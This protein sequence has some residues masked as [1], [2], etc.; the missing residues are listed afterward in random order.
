MAKT[1]HT[2]EVAEKTGTDGEKVRIE[3]TGTRETRSTEESRV[4]VES[5]PKQLQPDGR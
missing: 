5:G 4:D 3:T 2:H 1:E